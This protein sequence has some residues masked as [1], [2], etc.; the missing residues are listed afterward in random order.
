MRIRSGSAI[1]FAWVFLLSVWAVQAG[2]SR[3]VEGDR[4]YENLSDLTNAEATAEAFVA[5]VQR[6]VFVQ[7]EGEVKFYI[8]RDERGFVGEL[9]LNEPGKSSRR[10]EFGLHDIAYDSRVRRIEGTDREV[11]FLYE[12]LSFM[13]TASKGKSRYDGDRGVPSRI[14]RVVVDTTGR[15]GTVAMLRMVKDGAAVIM[16]LKQRL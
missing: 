15:M 8:R 11:R 5:S 10:V 14:Y 16:Q 6:G 4:G 12:E 2:C 9:V 13:L 1:G 7:G 3:K